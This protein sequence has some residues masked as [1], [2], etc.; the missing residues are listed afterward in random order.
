MV[1]WETISSL[2]VVVGSEFRQVLIIKDLVCSA[3]KFVPSPP[4]G[5]QGGKEVTVLCSRNVAR[6]I[7]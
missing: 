4:C 7:V 1:G 3:K 2:G 5:S 6:V